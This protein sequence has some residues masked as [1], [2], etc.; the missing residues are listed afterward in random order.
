M[1]RTS[2]ANATA[3]S[4]CKPLVLRQITPYATFLDPAE[5]GDIYAGMVAR[6][7]GP[8]IV[9]IMDGATANVIPFGL[10]A[11][12]RNPIFND[13]DGISDLGAF[14]VFQ[15]GPDVVL[16]ID[17][18]AFDTAQSYAVP[19]TGVPVKLFADTS[20]ALGKLTPVDPGGHM[21]VAELQQV[22]STNRIIVRL[23]APPTLN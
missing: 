5:T 21:A 6:R 14:S 16:Q 20:T 3:H 8:D 7:S 13:L 18:P 10:F 23:D 22:I 1:K 11:N 19:T 4:T 15:G 2:L 9:A 12:D 17:G